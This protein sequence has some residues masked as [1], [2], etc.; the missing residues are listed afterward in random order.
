MSLTDALMA[1]L[2]PH[3]VPLERFRDIVGRMLAAGI[4]VRDEDGVEQRLYDD[5]RRI[6]APLTWL[7]DLLR[8]ARYGGGFG[9]PIG[10]WITLLLALLVGRCGVHH[11]D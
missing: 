1:Q 4:M 6:E 11:H 8:T 7:N 10:I 3:N 9:V 2:E 5:M